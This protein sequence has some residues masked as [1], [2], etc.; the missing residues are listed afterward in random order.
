ME[1]ASLEGMC[2][3]E[4]Q[5]GPGPLETG[6][7]GMLRAAPGVQLGGR[8]RYSLSH[9]GQGCR[10]TFLFL[11]GRPAGLLLLPGAVLQGVPF[12]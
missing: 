11:L 12:T 6:V 5:G 9:G 3:C 7:Q 4:D 10:W 8:A 2:V 1:M